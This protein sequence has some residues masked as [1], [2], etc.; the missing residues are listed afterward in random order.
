MHAIIIMAVYINFITL[1]LTIIIIEE[2]NLC[3]DL[4]A[5]FVGVMVASSCIAFI[6]CPSIAA[7]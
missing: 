2:I 5:R 1:V 6:V 4:R 3:S 7:G